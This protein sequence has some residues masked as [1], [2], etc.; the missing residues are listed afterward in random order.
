[1]K[2]NIVVTKTSQQWIKNCFQQYEYVVYMEIE[3]LKVTYTFRV[4][5]I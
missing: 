1:M 4:I 3:E 5:I 2:R